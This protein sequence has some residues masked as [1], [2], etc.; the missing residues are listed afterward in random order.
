MKLGGL[1][2]PLFI[3][4]NENSP[5][6]IFGTKKTMKWFSVGSKLQSNLRETKKI[7]AK[8]ESSAGRVIWRSQMIPR[9]KE[10]SKKQDSSVRQ[11]ISPKHKEE[12]FCLPKYDQLQH[13]VQAETPMAVNG[14]GNLPN[15][16]GA[17]FQS[18]PFL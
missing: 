11:F 17:F 14:E 15:I 9:G 12:R 13:T 10:D 6:D 7:R 16:K 2:G 5:A 1:A 3:L 4:K 8:R 18:A